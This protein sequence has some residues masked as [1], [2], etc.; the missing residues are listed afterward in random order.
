MTKYDYY[1][2][3]TGRIFGNWYVVKQH[4]EGAKLNSQTLWDCR[5]TCGMCDTVRVVNAWKLLTRPFVMTMH[6]EYKDRLYKIWVGIKTRWFNSKSKIYK[7][8]GARGITICDEW[9]IYTN[10]RDWA[11]ANGYDDS[12]TIDRID[13]N[14]MYEPKNCRWI[15]QKEQARN[16]R[17]NHNVTIGNEAK[18]IAEWCEIYK[19]SPQ[20]VNS[21]LSR[22]WNEND[23]I[24]T[25]VN[26]GGTRC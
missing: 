23:A 12:L 2:D 5:C 19:I 20:T 3:L 4:N 13:T 24:T 16:T 14:G 17:F 7:F 6:R 25:P 26:M 9:M 1:Q 21:R 22:G 8:Y 15:P 11:I 10:F 18:C